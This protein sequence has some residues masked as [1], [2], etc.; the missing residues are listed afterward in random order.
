V[1]R[2]LFLGGAGMIGSACAAEAVRQGLDVTVVTRGATPAHRLPEGV[3]HI[4]ADVH[5]V[6]SL[7]RLDYDSVVNWVGYTPDALEW[8]PFLGQAGQYVF[9]GTCSAFARPAALLPIT[10]STPR[11][12]LAWPYPRDKVA[13]EVALEA[14]HRERGFP[15]TIVRP[16]HVYDDTVIPV[17][18]GW[19]A[20]ERMRRGRPVIVHGDGTSLWNLTHS[21]DFARAFVPLLAN[22]HTIGES[23]NVC[24][25]ELLTWN[26]IHCSLAAAAGVRDPLLVHRSSETIETEVPG[27]GPVLRHDFGHTVIYDTTK[28]RRLVPGFTPQVPFARAARNIIDWYDADPSRRK[29]DES[30]SAAFDRLAV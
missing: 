19:T 7:G 2:V 25:D 9:I 18:A 20:V 8:E 16:T 15:V 10:E 5:D 22:P 12:N 23:V 13:C 26:R 6:G 11:A 29:V 14:A 24:S 3:R 4:Q 28:L 1:I 30:L 27:W 21:A 17:L